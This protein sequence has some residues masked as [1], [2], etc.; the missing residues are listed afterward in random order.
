MRGTALRDFEF[1]V[2]RAD[3]HRFRP[4]NRDGRQERREDQANQG[5][6]QE[7]CECDGAAAPGD[8][9]VWLTPTAPTR[10]TS[11]GGTAA[12]RETSARNI[13]GAALF[14]KR[15]HTTSSARV[16]RCVAIGARAILLVLTPRVH[17]N[18]R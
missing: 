4:R 6:E 14:R 18:A 12:M 15:P 11:G 13:S 7:P 16:L 1:A 2:G 10:L 9:F 8:R 3:G 17:V 5:A